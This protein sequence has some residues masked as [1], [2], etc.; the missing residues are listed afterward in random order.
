M[1]K[2]KL[3]L[4]FL[5]V[6]IFSIGIF[7]TYVHASE[8]P[9]YSGQLMHAVNVNE[10]GSNISDVSSTQSNVPVSIIHDSQ[11]VNLQFTIEDNPVSINCVIKGRN[12]SEKV[13]H[14]SATCTN[15]HME[16][17]SAIYIEGFSPA[18]VY[19][20]YTQYDSDH[21]LQLI[22]KDRSVSTRDYYFLEVFDFELDNFSAIVNTAQQCEPDYWYTT[23]FLPVDQ[24][25]LENDVSTMSAPGTDRFETVRIEYKVDTNP[26]YAYIK[27]LVYNEVG[28]ISHSGV[29]LWKSSIGIAD[30]W[31][32]VI[33]APELSSDTSGI[34]IDNVTYN[35]TAPVNC[36]FFSTTIDGEATK[37]TGWGSISASISIGIGP[38][39]VSANTANLEEILNYGS[40]QLNAPFTSYKNKDGDFTREVSV[41]FD[42]KYCLKQ[43]PPAGH[44]EGDRYVVISTVKDYGNVPTSYNNVFTYWTIRVNASPFATLNHMVIDQFSVRLT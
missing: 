31:T 1:R 13:L 18:S 37:T 38:L 3:L 40:V 43:E 42:S 30:K 4:S 32:I 15:D 2:L 29:G 12:L 34:A 35:A 36:G 9:E 22:I 14:F 23:E 10:Y 5:L 17:L 20:D 25:L 24:C 16:V 19:T 7:N 27:L 33:G 11:G 41:A 28:N 44:D 21:V 8:A 39:S 26:I 6:F